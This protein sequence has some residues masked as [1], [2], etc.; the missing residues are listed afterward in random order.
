MD[1]TPVG[2]GTLLAGRF[3]LED[4]LDE[5]E[6]ARFWRATDK[7]LARSVAVHVI[8][9]DVSVSTRLVV[10]IDAAVSEKHA[11]YEQRQ[12]GIDIVELSTDRDGL[13][14]LQRVLSKYSNLQ[15]V[16]I[17]SHA[18][19]GVLR[20]GNSRIIAATVHDSIDTFA[21]INGAIK[22]N[23]D[24][25]FYGCNLAAGGDGGA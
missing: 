3:V 13:S 9:D 19:A 16:H 23:G 12:P 11:F 15:A 6:A 22:A 1:R 2:P 7:I 10:I 14:Q 24:I 4:L 21:A 25:L 17:I 8:A 18:D 20:L 5:T